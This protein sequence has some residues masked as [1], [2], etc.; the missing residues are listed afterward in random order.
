MIQ[1]SAWPKAEMGS[2]GPNMVLKIAA[3]TKRHGGS[4]PRVQLIKVEKTNN[5]TPRPARLQKAG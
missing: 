3:T 2:I 5:R 1:Q 4:T